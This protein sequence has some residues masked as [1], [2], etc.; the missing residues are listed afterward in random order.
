MLK[1]CPNTRVKRTWAESHVSSYFVNSTPALTAIPD[2][3]AQVGVPFHLSAVATDP[4]PGQVLSFSLLAGAPVGATLDPAT[5]L[6][7]WTPTPDYSWTTNLIGIQVSDNDPFP[8][9]DSQTF[10]VVV[11]APDSDGDGLPDWYERLPDIA[12]S[13]MMWTRLSLQHPV[14]KIRPSQSGADGS[15]QRRSFD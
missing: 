3:I 9:S 6:F 13:R 8:L 7:A 4:D 11:Q 15:Q 2:Q 14:P 1:T 5:G 12:F 10:S